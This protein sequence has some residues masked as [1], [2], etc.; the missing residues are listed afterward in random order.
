MLSEIMPIAWLSANRPDTPEN[1]APR[2]LIADL[3]V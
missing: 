2:M 3:L 1:N